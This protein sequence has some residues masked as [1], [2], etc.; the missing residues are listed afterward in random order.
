MDLLFWLVFLDTVLFL[1]EV[2]PPEIGYL[3]F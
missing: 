3:A 2:D 1:G